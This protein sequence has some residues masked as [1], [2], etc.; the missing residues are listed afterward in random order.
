MGYL[1]MFG[2]LVLG[3]LIHRV[4]RK[5][6]IEPGV[7]LLVVLLLVVLLLVG[8]LVRHLIGG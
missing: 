8:L 1:A 6:R 2:G 7:L 5:L 3:I 4:E